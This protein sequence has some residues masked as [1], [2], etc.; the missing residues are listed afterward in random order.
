MSQP[1][2]APVHRASSNATVAKPNCLLSEG[3]TGRTRTR[4]DARFGSPFP[5]LTGLG[6]NA[7]PPTPTRPRPAGNL[8][9]R[10]RTA[11]QQHSKAALQ[12]GLLPPCNFALRSQAEEQD[13]LATA[14]SALTPPRLP[15]HFDTRGYHRESGARQLRGI[16]L[17]WAWAAQHGRTRP[18]QA[19]HGDGEE[20]HRT[21][22]AQSPRRRG[23][24]CLIHGRT[25]G[26][27]G[28]GGSGG[29]T[30][31]RP[32]SP[33]TPTTTTTTITT[34]QQQ[35]EPIHPPEPRRAK[36]SE[37]PREQPGLL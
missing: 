15:S 7:T 10:Q 24:A 36:A 19:A 28:G 22:Q 11:A 6:C 16:C 32:P 17:A 34:T 23:S 20:W 33:P 4:V 14:R 1:Q 9:R 27:T 37:P 3:R 8:P 18:R 13:R 31:S 25:D 21:P 12:N 5:T 2:C 35:Q 26:R 29:G 30:L